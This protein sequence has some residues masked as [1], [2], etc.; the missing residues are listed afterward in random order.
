MNVLLFPV[1]DC[2]PN[3]RS[4]I[5]KLRLSLYITFTG[6]I[7]IYWNKSWRCLHGRRKIYSV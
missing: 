3:S 2:V 7:W 6:V 4:V 5:T 1:N